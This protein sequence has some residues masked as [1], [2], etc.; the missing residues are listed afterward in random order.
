MEATLGLARKTVRL[1]PYDPRWSQAFEREAS[2]LRKHLM[3]DI[4]EIEHIGSTAIPGMDAK[5]VIDL[6]VALPSLRAPET[7]YAAFEFL[8]YEHQPLDDVPDRLFFAK[9]PHHLR[10]HHVSACEKP[11]RFWHVHIAFRD[12]LR[13]DASL[14]AEYAQLKRT[15][16]TRFAS[17]RAAYTKGKES[18]VARVVAHVHGA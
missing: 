9:G 6:M 13:S 2:L 14:A 15:L 17:D 18:F 4:A 12:A 16:A 7:L 5:P 8:G 3:S 10:T 1:V 11:S